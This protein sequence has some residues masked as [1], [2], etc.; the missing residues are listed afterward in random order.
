VDH[1]LSDQIRANRAELMLRD[2]HLRYPNVT[3]TYDQREGLYACYVGD[4]QRGM[5]HRSPIVGS[6]IEGVWRALRPTGGVVMVC[7]VCGSAPM[8]VL[9]NGECHVCSER[10]KRPPPKAAFP[11]VRGD[12]GAR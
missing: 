3:L 6:A 1:A 12:D 10:F 9:R 5:R 8:R 11:A 2:L 7:A 4:E